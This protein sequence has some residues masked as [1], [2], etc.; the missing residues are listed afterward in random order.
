M[1]SIYV[2]G[3]YMDT[4]NTFNEVLNNV[5]HYRNKYKKSAIDVFNPNEC[6]ADH[7]GLTDDEKERL[8]EVL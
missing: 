4:C 7:D 6:D 2:D 5:L 8:C 1:Y 3:Y